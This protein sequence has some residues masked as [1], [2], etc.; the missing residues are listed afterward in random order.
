MRLII[1][2][3]GIKIMEKD[4]EFV[5]D[6]LLAEPDKKPNADEHFYC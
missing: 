5:Q 2:K 1:S 6:I 4:W 3:G